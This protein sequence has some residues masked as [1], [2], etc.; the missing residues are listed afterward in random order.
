MG[1][2][3][4]GRIAVDEENRLK[5]FLESPM[6]FNTTKNTNVN[7]IGEIDLKIRGILKTEIYGR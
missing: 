3:T 6:R 7:E 5:M 2:P 4:Y 1:S